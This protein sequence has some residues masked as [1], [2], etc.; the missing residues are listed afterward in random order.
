MKI[1]TGRLIL[2][3]L[4]SFS[5][6]CN[7]LLASSFLA[8][9]PGYGI[10]TGHEF[11]Q[12]DPETASKKTKKVTVVAPPREIST[13]GKASSPAPRRQ[14]VVVQPPA[15]IVGI[16]SAS[17]PTASEKV[18]LVP[19]PAPGKIAI[20]A[21]PAIVPAGKSAV[22]PLSAISVV[23]PPPLRLNEPQTIRPPKPPINGQVLISPPEPVR[24][25]T[26][27]RSAGITE[28]YAPV[29][30][31][32]KAVDTGTPPPIIPP[33]RQ[34]A[35]VIVS[36]PEP[37][38]IAAHKPTAQSPRATGP[39]VISAP[40]EIDV[41]LPAIVSSAK[42]TA[43][44]ENSPVRATSQNV[45]SESDTA[46]KVGQPLPVLKYEYDHAADTVNQA[47]RT[48]VAPV[49]VPAPA[50]LTA[51]AI[52]SPRR[53][54][55]LASNPLFV[56]SE[57]PALELSKPE[58]ITAY[59]TA[60]EADVS[61][62]DEDAVGM[63]IITEASG[64]GS[65]VYGV[66]SFDS[67][68]RVESTTD[69]QS[70]FVEPGRSFNLSF[71]TTNISGK[72]GNFIEEFN[73]PPG[74]ELTFPPAEFGLEPMESY[75]SIVMISAPAYLP[76][77]EHQ[78]SY[79]VLD[80]RNQM[81]HGSLSF[82]FNI[83]ATVDLKFIVE[84][85][86]SSVLDGES[87]T[88]KGK[89]YNNSNATFSVGLSLT[90][91]KHF[92]ASVSR[93]RAILAPGAFVDLE[94]TC[95]T[96]S[97]GIRTPNLFTSL[98]VRDLGRKDRRKI[99]EQSIFI[100]FFTRAERKIDLKKRLPIIAKYTA[101]SDQGIMHSQFEVK[102]KGI[103]DSLGERKIDFLLRP[104]AEKNSMRYGLANEEA[105]IMYDAGNFSISLGDHGFGVSELSKYYSG[106]GIGVDYQFDRRSRAGFVAY[107]R[108]WSVVP[109]SGKG[110]Y[111]T[112]Q[113]TD[114]M[115]L[116]FSH[117]STNS[118]FYAQS[119]DE[120]FSAL[121]FSYKAND[122]S[123][124]EGEV[125]RKWGLALDDTRSISYRINYSARL[126]R[127]SIFSFQHSDIG[128]IY[129]GDLIGVST[130]NSSLDVPIAPKISATAGFSKNKSRTLAPDADS[131][132]DESTRK[133][134]SLNFRLSN[135]RFLSLQLMENERRDY[136]HSKYNDIE[137]IAALNLNQRFNKANFGY[138]FLRGTYDE[139]V[140]SRSRQFKTH[141]LTSS[142]KLIE[143]LTWVGH[144]SASNYEGSSQSPFNDSITFG[145]TIEFG[146]LDNFKTRLSYNRTMY[147]SMPG[148]VSNM[149]LS[150]NYRFD[151]SE[152]S[153]KAVENK[154]TTFAAKT[155]VYYQMSF[156][157]HFGVPVSRNTSLGAF[158]GILTEETEDGVRPVE[159]VVMLMNNLAA[160]TDKNGRFVFA[161]VPPGTYT[162]DLDRRQREK[163]WLSDPELPATVVVK[164]ARLAV[165]DVKLEPGFMFSGEIVINEEHMA[166]SQ[167]AVST[168]ESLIAPDLLGFRK[169]A[170]GLQGVMLEVRKEGKVR[171]VTTNSSG[172]FIF[173]GLEAGEWKF[174]VNR[175]T[176]P[177]GYALDETEKTI[178]IGEGLDSKLKLTARKVVRQIEMVGGD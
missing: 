146:Q 8:R 140:F 57:T 85:Q 132:A 88:V 122:W 177:I 107:K 137:N 92:R 89:L 32:P 105:R 91:Q 79:R 50:V 127:N 82:R 178:R 21:S 4:I 86:P 47:I 175:N 54:V 71:R 69:L 22:K 160:V 94:I 174:R 52:T 81:V 49:S 151:D 58:T 37:F 131:S 46:E 63:E 28:I 106:K 116:K 104:Q 62:A 64:V 113:L 147:D 143:N 20:V 128:T 120:K 41:P 39:V 154:R 134:V 149:D 156:S 75:N 83:N 101:I 172:G 29:L 55:V 61:A 73:M 1:R 139:I 157:Q 48:K 84:E 56:A 142:Y 144:F 159:N 45:V 155:T 169:I 42:P 15:E 133:N 100:R 99:H 27:P 129:A 6:V 135:H 138:S 114:R 158:A 59:G 148:Y 77:G 31:P 70:I 24:T 109:L 51:P 130:T 164:G 74:F 110:F 115:H 36:P 72:A 25:V 11:D 26:A 95:S 162:V 103:V 141:R 171:Q 176:L 108:I 126:R 67:G 9:R 170:G 34:S 33:R 3:V 80:P 14:V 145:N 18:R 38:T 124:I 60:G 93:D 119:P 78:F 163:G 111:L 97:R 98:V 53:E 121:A 173:Y 2:L 152:L 96:N 12:L 43:F 76:A 118:D 165:L 35:P 136:L 125:A 153:F 167:N 87:F 30:V 44:A 102:G 150:L 13:V 68:L 10:T 66:S 65:P 23:Q 117:L 123:I 161:D 5:L 16:A 17:R 40:G 166:V 90:Q 19:P 112:R 7:D 168:L